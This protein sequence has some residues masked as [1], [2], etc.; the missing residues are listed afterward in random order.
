[1]GKMQG[2]AGCSP[3]CYTSLITT[4]VIIKIPGE[5]TVLLLD[6]NK[7]QGEAGWSPIC[8]NSSIT[9]LY[10]FSIQVRT[11]AKFKIYDIISLNFNSM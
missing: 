10:N 8:L 5:N 9:T 6:L 2:K 7:V 11:N 4:F 1:M 3:Y